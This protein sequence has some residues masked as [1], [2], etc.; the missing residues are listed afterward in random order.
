MVTAKIVD[1]HQR[2]KVS[3]GVYKQIKING[4]IL[5]YQE[6][7][8]SP[9]GKPS[10]ILSH[11]HLSD[12]RTWTP[13]LPQLTDHFHIIS[14]SRRF[15]WPNDKIQA[16]EHD[17]WALHANDLAELIISLKLAPVHI[18]GNSSGAA[19]PLHLAHTRPELVKSLILEEPP[20]PY[21]FLPTLPPSPWAVINLLFTHPTAFLPVLGFGINVMDPVIKHCKADPPRKDEALEVFGPGACT[22]RTWE[23]I[24]NDPDQ[25]RM[26]QVLDNTD[27]MINVFRYDTV[28]RTG[29]KELRQV[30][31]PVLMLTGTA[32]IAAQK[33]I[34]WKVVREVG[35][36]VKREVYIEGAG[37]LVHEDAPDEVG[38]VVRE[39]IT[40]IEVNK[41]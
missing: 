12:L 14:Y 20:L 33:S 4:S 19:I 24:K 10:L 18:L 13:L 28:L 9:I 2:T 35:S 16:S 21:V 29:V 37:H 32:T 1:S 8:T 25:S 23:Q 38:K 40:E 3:P 15:Y 30:T 5:S 22:V 31:C 17:D 11:A 6:Y 36:E 41:T 7:N 27:I 26:A 39:W 34:D